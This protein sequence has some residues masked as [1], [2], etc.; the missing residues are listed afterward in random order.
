MYIDIVIYCMFDIILKIKVK[1]KEKFYLNGKC[2]CLV[3]LK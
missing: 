2:Y 1:L 3:Y